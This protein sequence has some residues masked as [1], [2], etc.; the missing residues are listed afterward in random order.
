M[1]VDERLYPEYLE[2]KKSIEDYES[3]YGPVVLI[4]VYLPDIYDVEE[5]RQLEDHF[6]AVYSTMFNRLMPV[7][8]IPKDSAKKEDSRLF[9]QAQFERYKET[10]EWLSY[11]R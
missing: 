4:V 7:I 11:K 1:L 9:N 5:K 8:A 6:F 2:A 10:E 3:I